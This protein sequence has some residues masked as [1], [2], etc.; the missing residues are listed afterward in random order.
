MAGGVA[1]S[2]AAEATQLR[3][4]AAAREVFALMVDPVLTAQRARRNHFHGIGAA[5]PLGADGAIAGTGVGA[6]GTLVDGASVMPA[7]DVAVALA[8]LA[9]DDLWA[10]GFRDRL[11]ALTELPDAPVFAGEDGAAQT[12]EFNPLRTGHEWGPSPL[13]L[14]PAA[15]R[16]LLATHCV[17]PDGG[18]TLE[19][20]SAIARTVLHTPHAHGVPPAA[21][22]RTQSAAAM[23]ASTSNPLSTAGAGAAAGTGA[24]SHSALT[25]LEA[26]VSRAL[27]LALLRTEVLGAQLESTVTAAD[28]AALAA[29]RATLGGA[30]NF[31]TRIGKPARRRSIGLELLVGSTATSATA[32]HATPGAATKDPREAAAAPTALGK[33]ATFTARDL[34]RWGEDVELECRRC[35]AAEATSLDADVTEDIAATEAVGPRRGG[36]GASTVGVSARAAGFLAPFRASSTGEDEDNDD[37]S[38]SA[39]RS[40]QPQELTASERADIAETAQWLLQRATS[41]ATGDATSI[42]GSVAAGRGSIAAAALSRVPGESLSQMLIAF[43]LFV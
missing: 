28:A 38:A 14:G 15:H 30:S 5:L 16:A 39:H 2:V 18:V 43:G 27:H 21:G 10:L 1:P 24:H 22:G 19:E 6:V 26:R 11:R 9:E 12:A 23:A 17:D 35:A 29:R 20:F 32:A 4:G 36:D 34:Q 42:A 13:F 3:R 33:G 25:A 8:V 40:Q 37:V 41:Y 7:R 31:T